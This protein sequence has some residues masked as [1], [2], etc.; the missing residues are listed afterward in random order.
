MKILVIGGGWA[1]I[2]AAVEA[3]GRGHEV[4]LVEERG[5]IGGRARS[6][7]DKETGHHIDNG[8]HVMMG[9]YNAF[10][11][12]LRTLGTEHLLEP[13]SSLTVTFVDAS[14]RK[15]TLDTSLLPGRLGVVAGILRLTGV[16]LLS[17][18]AAIRLALSIARGSTTGEGTT[19]AEFLRQGGQPQDIIQ[20]FWEPVV[21]ATL[22][23]S[24]E[25]ASAELLV[26]VMKLAFMGSST[27]SAL[28]IPTCGLSDLVAPLTSWMDERGGRVL[29][30]TSVDQLIVDGNTC[31]KAV[32][33]NGSIES[34][35]AVVSCAPQRALDR[36]CTASGIG[37]Q[38]P[39]APMMSPIASVYL[40]YNR[41]W[42][43]DELLATIGTTIQWVFNKH[44]I[45]PG[46]V[47]LTVSAGNDIVGSSQE[48]IVALCDAELRMLLPEA[49][50]AALLKGL[51]IKEKTATP[52]LGPL[53]QRPATNH[54][55]A[56]VSNLF[57]AGD[58]TSTRLPATIEG[59]ARSGIAAIESALHAR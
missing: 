17:R 15:H 28:L 22:N 11:N 51:V 58:W 48:E 46:L 47:A 37:T 30:H 34:V 50:D 53:T 5:Y 13:Q 6:F 9:C 56:E 1:G 42:M 57:I 39:A 3:A 21:L 32:L 18:I 43:Q 49:Q 36:L 10:L 41:Q 52:L 19:C 44:R 54:F 31:T 20:R 45:A 35:D 2:A 14:Q 27:D 59:A 55:C 40:W 29:L 23:A 8:Q 24:L 25:T 33:S 7:V 38:L 12:I 16:G 4:L 26:A